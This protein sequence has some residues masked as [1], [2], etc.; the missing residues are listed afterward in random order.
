MTFMDKYRKGE[1][2]L[3]DID[4]YIDQWHEKS[5]GTAMDLPGFLGM[6]W[7]QYAYWVETGEVS[8]V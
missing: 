4:D 3:E 5:D 7:G 1:A 2:K 8:N 6:T